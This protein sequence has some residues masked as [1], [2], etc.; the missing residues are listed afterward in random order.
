MTTE[1]Q[2]LNDTDPDPYKV[3]KKRTAALAKVFDETT[4][5]TTQAEVIETVEGKFRFWNLAGKP[6]EWDGFEYDSYKD[7]ENDIS[8][9]AL[10]NFPHLTITFTEVKES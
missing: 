9:E 1:P 7:L 6:A 5:T 4:N 8:L 10:G 2:Q 3:E